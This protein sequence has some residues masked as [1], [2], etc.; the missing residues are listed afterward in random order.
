MAKRPK[1]RRVLLKLSGE[2]FGTAGAGIDVNRLQKI[3]RQIASVHRI[4][5]QLGIVIGGGNIVRGKSLIDHCASAVTAHTMGMLATVINGLV[6]QDSLTGLKV[7]VRLQTAIPMQGVAEPYV[8][9]RC[10]K[11]LEEKR[12]V[13]FAAGTGSPFFTTDTA[14]A[15]RAREI[16]ADVLLKATNVDSVYSADPKRNPKAKRYRRLTYRDVIEQDLG[17]MDATAFTLCREAA[18]PI[19]VFG[20]QPSGNIRRVVCGESVGTL[21]RER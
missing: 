11:H 10:L 4:G 14:A 8:R 19:I 5:V 20:L 1:Y 13:I 6:L 16:D 15:L 9:K 21:I 12:V 17:V 3:S 2:A 7:D 18:M